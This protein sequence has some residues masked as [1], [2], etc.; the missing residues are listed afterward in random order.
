[1]LDCGHR[2]S[3]MEPRDEMGPKPPGPRRK[4][5]I[6]YHPKSPDASVERLREL[7]GILTLNQPVP[8]T[9][10]LDDEYPDESTERA[11]D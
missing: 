3:A 6:H 5:D 4:G 2:R 7:A 9:R 10:F 1:M 8:F 11:R